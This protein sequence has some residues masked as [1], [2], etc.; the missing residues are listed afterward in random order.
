MN[1]KYNCKSD[2]RGNSQG[3]EFQD[4]TYGKG[5][6]VATQKLIVQGRPPEYRCT[7]CGSQHGPEAATK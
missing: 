7:V 6:R 5:I 2:G 4:A 1:I 3:A